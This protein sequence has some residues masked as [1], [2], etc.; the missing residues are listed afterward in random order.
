MTLQH[1]KAERRSPGKKSCRNGLTASSQSEL[2]TIFC[3]HICVG[4]V[5]EGEGRGTTNAYCGCRHELQHLVRLYID[6]SLELAGS[7]SSRLW[8]QA[9]NAQVVDKFIS[10]MLKTKMGA[11]LDKSA[12]CKIKRHYQHARS[13]VV[14]GEGSSYLVLLFA[15]LCCLKCAVV[16]ICASVGADQENVDPNQGAGDGTEE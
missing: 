6:C 3:K 11:R 14:K 15:D 4:G 12:C 13:K 2:G 9:L 16:S 7:L 1:R 10:A 8:W 5:Q